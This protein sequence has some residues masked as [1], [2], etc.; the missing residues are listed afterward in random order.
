MYYNFSGS[1]LEHDSAKVDR[2]LS[3]LTDTELAEDGVLANSAAES[4]HLWK[5]RENCSL[6]LRQGGFSD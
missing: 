5:I 2:F 3:R 6:A 4:A 1:D